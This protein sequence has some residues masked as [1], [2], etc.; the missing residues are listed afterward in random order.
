MKGAPEWR[1]GAARY[2][3][4]IA[5][6]WTVQLDILD[7]PLEPA[8]RLLT[9]HGGEPVPVPESVLVLAGGINVYE[10]R[11]GGPP[12][13]LGRIEP[14]WALLSIG[15]YETRPGVRFEAAMPSSVWVCSHRELLKLATTDALRT[16]ALITHLTIALEEQHWA[17]R[18][19]AQRTPMERLVA[20]LLRIA[21]DSGAVAEEGI[22]LR[23]APDVREMSVLAGVSRESAVINLEWLVHLGALRREQGRLWVSDLDELRTAGKE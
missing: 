8:G 11:V 13:K 14:G 5:G 16:E 12:A 18:M 21:E 3:L 10:E 23:G 1:M 7:P 4:A 15:E 9:Y 22:L 19:S 2:A 17:L 20:L 6:Y